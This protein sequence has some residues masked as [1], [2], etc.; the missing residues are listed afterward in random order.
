MNASELI[1]YRMSLKDVDAHYFE[2]APDRVFCSECGSVQDAS[3]VPSMLVVHS[4][5]PF[6][7][8]TTY[9]G[10]ALCS[11]ATKELMTSEGL[12]V[13]FK[14]VNS[15]IGLHHFEPRERLAFDVEKRRTQ[16]I[17]P[18]SRCGRFAEIIGSQPIFLRDVYAPIRTG[19]FRTDVEFGS[20]RSKGPELL[21]GI[22]TKEKLVK[23]KFG[24]C[25]FLPVTRG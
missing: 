4:G 10:K 21:V 18:C 2:N 25:T 17:G 19:L 5:G 14:V 23:I 6:G 3:Y 22:E 16:F 8:G 15:H 12:A 13:D 9:D 11:T 7:L 20:G 1:A 24:G